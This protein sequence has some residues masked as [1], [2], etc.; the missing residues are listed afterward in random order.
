MT[1][2]NSP[3]TQLYWGTE[4]GMAKPL[5]AY[6]IDIPWKT[7]QFAALA[8][9]KI[10]GGPDVNLGEIS[11][12]CLGKATKEGKLYHDKDGGETNAHTIIK[13]VYIKGAYSHIL[14]HLK[15]LKQS[16]YTI[17]DAGANIGTCSILLG[18]ELENCTIYAMEV[19]ETTRSVLSKNLEDN[20]KLRSSSKVRVIPMGLIGKH[21]NTTTIPSIVPFFHFI[22]QTSNSTA[23]ETLKIKHDSMMKALMDPEQNLFAHRF[24]ASWPVTTGVNS[25]L[26]CFLRRVVQRIMVAYLYRYKKETLKLGSIEDAIASSTTGA[27]DDGAIESIDLVKIDTEGMEYPNLLAIS[28]PMWARIQTAAVEIHDTRE[29]ELKNAAEKLKREGLTNVWH[30]PDFEYNKRGANKHLLTASRMPF[31][32][33]VEEEMIA[34]GMVNVI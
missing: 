8:L 21:P 34:E 6:V 16:K 2:S 7:F 5:Y 31:A 30:L 3:I 15:S 26:P 29:D 25:W 9:R 33:A 10:R 13:E 27:A 20:A 14:S 28:K 19:V 17:V 23:E 11:M 22:C 1:N 24:G 12:P 18:S 32:K 4:V